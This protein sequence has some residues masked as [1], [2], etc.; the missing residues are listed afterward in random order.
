MAYAC[1]QALCICKAALCVLF[2]FPFKLMAMASQSYCMQVKRQKTPT[3]TR[4]QRLMYACDRVELYSRAHDKVNGSKPSVT[5]WLLLPKP[6]A[7]PACKN[8]CQAGL[9]AVVLIVSVEW[10]G[11]EAVV[12]YYANA[13]RTTCQSGPHALLA[14]SSPFFIWL[15]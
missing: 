8:A 7:K 6:S 14:G 3:K 13:A 2:C 5:C 10:S 15:H 1:S 12:S 11:L 9:E 4:R